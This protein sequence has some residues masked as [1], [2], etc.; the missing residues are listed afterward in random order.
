MQTSNLFL[1]YCNIDYV[2]LSALTVA[3]LTMV[4]TYD[5]NCIYK[6]HF[7]DRM[8]Q[9]PDSLR[10]EQGHF[11]LSFGVPKFHLPSHKL[12]CQA[13]HSLNLMPGVGRTD[14]E[15]IERNWAEINAVANS[16]KEMGPGLRHDTL[17]DHFGHHNW[18]KLLAWVSFVAACSSCPC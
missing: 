2:F 3:V 7:W 5:V 14:G 11:D 13:P 10:L 15:G 6:L 1:S 4:L 9:M 16:T 8:K 18:R 17:D 12:A